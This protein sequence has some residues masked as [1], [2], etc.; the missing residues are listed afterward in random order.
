MKVRYSGETAFLELSH[1]KI[2]KVQSVEKGWYRIVDD[3]GED[4][5]YPPDEFEVVEPNDGSTPV[6][7]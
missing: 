2:Y 5:L 6:F 1:N 7:E 3:T 4:Y